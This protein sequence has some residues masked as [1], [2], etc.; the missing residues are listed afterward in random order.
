MENFMNELEKYFEE[1]PREKIFE[2]WEKSKEFDN[3]GIAADEFLQNTI[4][5]YPYLDTMPYNGNKF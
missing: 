1:T 4:N 3:I 2:D 5:N